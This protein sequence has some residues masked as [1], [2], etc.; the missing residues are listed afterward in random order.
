MARGVCRLR[1]PTSGFMA[2]RRSLLERLPLNPLG[3]KIVLEVVVKAGDVRVVEVPIVFRDRVQGQSK[4]SLRAQL[5]YIAHLARLY[6]YR[7]LRIGRQPG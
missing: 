4:L 3:W 1:D 5:Q 7:Y 2:A 6:G